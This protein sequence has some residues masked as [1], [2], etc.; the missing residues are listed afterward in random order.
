M[1]RVFGLLLDRC[2]REKKNE[3]LFNSQYEKLKLYDMPFSSQEDIEALTGGLSRQMNGEST[4]EQI[5]KLVKR[6]KTQ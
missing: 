2:F 1:L 4:I 5:I 6:Q 3:D